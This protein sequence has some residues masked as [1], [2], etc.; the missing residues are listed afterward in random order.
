MGDWL[1]ALGMMHLYARY[2]SETE[3]ETLSQG[4]TRPAWREVAVA[5]RE[6]MDRGLDPL[7]PEAEPLARR[8][9]ELARETSGG[10]PVVLLKLRNMLR[11]E[12]R[13][14]AA[15]GMSPELLDWLERAVAALR[16]REQGG[17]EAGPGPRGTALG[18]ARLRAA[19]QVLDSPLVFADPLAL[20]LLGPRGEAD[21]RANPSR[22]DAGRL[23]SLRTSVA[24]RARV[25]A[26]AWAEARERGT[27]Q[28]VILGAGLDTLAYREDAPEA[29]FFE[30]DHPRTQSL[31]RRMLAAAGMTEPANLVFVPLDLATGSLGEALVRSGLSPAEPAFVSWLGVTMYLDAQTVLA[32]LRLLAGLTPGTEVVFDYP[33]VPELLSPRER[34]GREAVMARAAGQGEPWKSAFDPATLVA[35]LADM[36]FGRVEDLDAGRLNARYLSDRTDGLRKNGVT[37]IVRASGGRER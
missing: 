32:T 33:V 24:V 2:F 34:E 35:A 12:E 8:A 36:G 3:L 13:A 6:A 16:E 9:L 37:R 10:D 7:G 1:D 26:D 14:R 11:Q 19:H 25:A 23:R 20:R 31:K 15:A 27:R 28:C 21:I 22:Y 30:V 4:K 5:A 29:T 18:V 17:Q